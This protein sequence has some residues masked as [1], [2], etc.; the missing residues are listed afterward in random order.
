MRLRSFL[1]LAALH[2]TALH[3]TALHCTALHCTAQGGTTQVVLR[4]TPQVVLRGDRVGV[5]HMLYIAQ[6]H[7]TQIHTKTTRLP[8]I[9]IFHDKLVT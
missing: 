1:W 9:V 6:L 2:C 3:C 5:M 4:G 8:P 7:T